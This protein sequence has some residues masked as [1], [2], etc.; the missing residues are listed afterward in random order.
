MLVILFGQES[1]GDGLITIPTEPI[2]SI[3]RPLELI[4]AVARG[5]ADD[6]AL[7]SLY[8]AAIRDTIA[9]FEETGSLGGTD[10][11]QRKYHNSVREGLERFEQTPPHVVVC[12]LATPGEDGFA[13]VR[14]VRALRASSATP[15]VA[16]TAFSR[17][18]DRD[19]ALASGFDAYL[20]KPVD[21]E[22]LAATVLRLSVGNA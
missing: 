8:N 1:V 2:G 12:D 15:V 3:P 17:P 5:I 21:P 16:L 14:A 18:E 22:E 10:G 6:S 7:D 11:E 19:R 9:R 13:F 4:E 20:S